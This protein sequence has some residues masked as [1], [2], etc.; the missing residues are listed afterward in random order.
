[1][2]KVTQ[3]TTPN[4]C[5]AQNTAPNHLSLG[6]TF[7]T[8][9]HKSLSISGNIYRGGEGTTPDESVSMTATSEMC[10]VS[11]LLANTGHTEYKTSLG[12]VKF[13]CCFL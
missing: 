11:P 13:M 4:L 9:L 3:D 12:S 5:T 2:N 10:T 7:P 8:E 1:M 6:V